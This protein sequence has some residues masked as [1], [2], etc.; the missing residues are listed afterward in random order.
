MV[1]TLLLHG[2]GE[3][4][5]NNHTPVTYQVRNAKLY[6]AAI[7]GSGAYAKFLTIHMVMI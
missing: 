5:M 6:A 1:Q 2:K 4:D 7:S 3:R